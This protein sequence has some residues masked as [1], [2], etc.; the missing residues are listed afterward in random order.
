MSTR[1]SEL[2]NNC[3]GYL[4]ELI[5][6]E[7]ELKRVLTKTI[8]MTKEELAEYGFCFNSDDL[9]PMC[10]NCTRLDKDC[11]GS[12]NPVWTGCVHKKVLKVDYTTKFKQLLELSGNLKTGPFNERDTKFSDLGFELFSQGGSLIV[13]FYPTTCNWKVSG[14]DEQSHEEVIMTGSGW[15]ELIKF[16]CT[17]S[18]ITWFYQMTDEQIKECKI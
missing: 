15:N 17:D 1:Q 10:L 6:D 4:S 16:L 5:S 2:L 7:K 13:I 11:D 14:Y 18:D 9:N 12:T 3:F 8:G